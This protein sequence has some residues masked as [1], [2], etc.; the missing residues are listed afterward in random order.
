MEINESEK[1]TAR[2]IP[3]IFPQLIDYSFLFSKSME[4]ELIQYRKPVG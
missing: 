2:I 1:D 4:T 3:I